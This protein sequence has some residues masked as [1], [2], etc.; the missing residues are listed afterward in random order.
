MDFVHQ[1]CLKTTT[2]TVVALDFTKGQTFMYPNQHGR[3]STTKK[4]SFSPNQERRSRLTILS[5]LR[6]AIRNRRLGILM[7]GTVL[8]HDTAAAQQTIQK[9]KREFS[10]YRTS[11]RTIFTISFMSRNDLVLE[12]AIRV[13]SW[14]Q[15]FWTGWNP[16]RKVSMQRTYKIWC[17]DT[18]SVRKQRRLCEK[19]K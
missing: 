19:G 15:W 6:R 16:R 10:E 12:G 3:L 11:H 2:H 9:L 14:K 7:L 8:L 5:K 17:P 4:V 1:R 13:R 18:K